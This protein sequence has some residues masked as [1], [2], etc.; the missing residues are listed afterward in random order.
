M[1]IQPVR[2]GD[3]GRR[4]V[5]I[6]CIFKPVEY[7]PRFPSSSLTGHVLQ[8]FLVSAIAHGFLTATVNGSSPGEIRLSIVFISSIRNCRHSLKSAALLH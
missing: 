5:S 8:T 4:S 7:S 1:S 2:L 3:M 6:V